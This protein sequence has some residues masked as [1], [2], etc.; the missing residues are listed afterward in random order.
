MNNSERGS[1]TEGIE[2]LVLDEA[3]ARA[4]LGGV[5]RSFLYRRE[6]EG[7]LASVRIGGRRMWPV[8]TLRAYVDRCAAG[9]GDVPHAP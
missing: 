6:R 3:N 4:F 8:E 5:S 2:P 7:H 1:V 9:D